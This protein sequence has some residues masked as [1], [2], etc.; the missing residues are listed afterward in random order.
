MVRIWEKL[1]QKIKQEYE[2]AEGE[3]VQ[4]DVS[5]RG[6]IHVTLVT[7]LDVTKENLKNLLEKEIEPYSQKYQIGFLDIYSVKQSVEF[8]LT[9]Q[10]KKAAIVPGQTRSAPEVRTLWSK[11]RDCR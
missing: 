6:K 10:S 9:K 1:E 2:L 5:K 4:V 11:T 3:W 8:H 7:D